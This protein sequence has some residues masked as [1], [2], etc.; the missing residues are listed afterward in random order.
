MA[1]P[2]TWTDGEVFAIAQAAYMCG[3]GGVDSDFGGATVGP[4]FKEFMPLM[5]DACQIRPS[6]A[7]RRRALK[8]AG[9]LNGHLNAQLRRLVPSMRSCA[10]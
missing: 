4:R 8:M 2:R 9:L 3:M 1:T 5:E 6:V 10:S 7:S